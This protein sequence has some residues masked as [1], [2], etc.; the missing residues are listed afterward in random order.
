MSFGESIRKCLSLYCTFSGRASRSEYWWWNLFSFIIGMLLSIAI[1]CVSGGSSHESLTAGVGTMVIWG[2][3][4]L[5]YLALFLPS[6]SVLFRRLHDTGRSGW[7]WL[8][9]FIPFG[10]IVLLIF[11][12]MPS[13]PYTNK[14]GD[15]PEGVYDNI[16]PSYYKG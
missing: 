6:L 13:Q 3:S 9:S 2:I 14:Y 5:I 15:V 4:G 1:L 12:L 8:I 11:T 10:N 16:P 7:W